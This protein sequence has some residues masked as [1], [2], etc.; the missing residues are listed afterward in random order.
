MNK[1]RKAIVLFSGGLDSIL[2]AKIIME[3]G[4]HV[5]AINFN[6]GFGGGEN[7]AIKAAQ[8]LGIKLHIVDIVNEFKDVLIC[9]KHGYGAN[10][11]PCLDCKILMV[12]E[13]LKWIRI[14][15][16]DFIISGEVIGQRPK[17]QRKDT[18]PVVARESEANDLLVRPLCAKLLPPTLPEKEHWIDR[19]KLYGINGRS[20]KPQVEL[21]EKFGLKDYPQPAGGCLLTDPNFCARLQDHWD[22]HNTKDYD[23]GDIEL[24]KVGRHLRIPDYPGS[25]LIIGRNEA[26]NSVLERYQDKYITIYTISHG[27]PVTLIQAVGANDYSSLQKFILLAARI[28][29]RFSS[30]RS[31]DKVTMKICYPEGT[32]ESIDVTPIMPDE[33]SADWYV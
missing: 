10:L 21:A 4:I 29:A 5:E 19:E 26:E 7:P 23:K 13:A 27:G 14:H 18:M 6:I 22:H 12:K 31:A 25:K 24:L 3:Q 28:T 20:R 8:Q 17:S 15:D 9:P 16:F 30:G 2:A 11:N 1:Q 33:I 32:K